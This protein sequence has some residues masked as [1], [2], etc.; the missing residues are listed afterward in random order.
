[1]TG[2][3]INIQT[4]VDFADKRKKVNPWDLTEAA[5]S[6]YLSIKVVGIKNTIVV[7][8][9]GGKRVEVTGEQTSVYARAFAAH[10]MRLINRWDDMNIGRLEAHYAL[11]APIS[12]ILA[13][14]GVFKRAGADLAC[15]NVKELVETW[16]T[17]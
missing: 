16:A 1:M 10:I 4:L 7:Y 5:E 12:V 8:N 13:D 11:D 15:T 14:S 3:K 2:R 6:F 9:D 17:D